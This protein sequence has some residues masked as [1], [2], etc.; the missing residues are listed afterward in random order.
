M[1][2][3]KEKKF[4]LGGMIAGAWLLISG[5]TTLAH[6]W[7]T[8][9]Y[10]VKA[11][12]QV[13]LDV[14]NGEPLLDISPP[15]G[16]L[17]SEWN[18][19]IDELRGA[20]AQLEKI[21]TDLP[22]VLGDNTQ[23]HYDPYDNLANI[24][25]MRIADLR[26]TLTCNYQL[27]CGMKCLH[28][29]PWCLDDPK[30]P[31]PKQSDVL[32]S[33]LGWHAGQVDEQLND[34]TLFWRPTSSNLFDIPLPDET[35]LLALLAGGPQGMAA[36]TLIKCIAK[37]F[38]G[39]LCSIGEWY[40]PSDS[41][42]N[43]F[44]AVGITLPGV[45]TIQDSAYVGL[46]HFINM[47]TQDGEYNDIRGMLYE[48]AGPYGEPGVVDKSILLLG[49][50]GLTLDATRSDGVRYEVAST[51]H[52]TPNEWSGWKN[53]GEI[54]FHP[55][56]NLG[57]WGW[58]KKYLIDPTGASALGW[59]L[60]ALADASQPQHLSSTTSWGHR[61]FEDAVNNLRTKLI[62]ISPDPR[63]V[64]EVDFQQERRIL[65]E[66]Y[67]WWVTTESDDPLSVERLVT[68]V[69]QKSWQY[70]K[71][72][73]DAIFDDSGSGDYL[74]GDMVCVF[75][76]CPFEDYKDESIESVQ[77]NGTA[78]FDPT[79]AALEQS[80]G[81]MVA[82]LTHA[83][84]AAQPVEI[85]PATK[86]PEEGYYFGPAEGC[87]N[88]R[89]ILCNVICAVT[90]GHCVEGTPP[91]NWPSLPPNIG[92]ITPGPEGN[93][94]GSPGDSC[95][96]YS[97][98]QDELVCQDGTCRAGRFGGCL[99]NS[100]C[101]QRLICESGKCLGDIGSSCFGDSYCAE[102]LICKEEQG[103]CLVPYGG[104]CE[105]NNE[106]AVGFCNGSTCDIIR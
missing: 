7:Q 81:A 62:R 34:T 77:G 24:G 29:D 58:S 27:P 75:G 47:R 40:V 15:S 64:D 101:I 36:V 70:Y 55:V 78:F 17:E 26:Y 106:C 18:A 69:A 19:Y 14:Q 46:W 54:E 61:P 93:N 73:G 82:F 39:D 32:G 100:H 92:V 80:V 66:S 8:H 102:R 21:R 48:Q 87:D 98:C 42:A 37:L 85:D 38:S 30:F 16:V 105:S 74:L 23:C 51:T 52:R 5:G 11:A 95:K 20:R 83:A 57:E 49:D 76:W 50:L 3:T 6:N 44:E 72:G 13:M 90:P 56:D 65:E 79:E 60:H 1:K 25:Q 41:T 35:T 99:E 71:N 53:I 45:G 33:V 88:C 94:P 22:P 2:M 10:L 31:N 103:E 84:N 43:P 104:S 97:D 63:E 68:N 96:S 67:H 28:N 91:D 9:S 89:N 12:A 4:F 86:C 59:P